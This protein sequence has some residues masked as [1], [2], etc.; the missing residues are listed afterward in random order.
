MAR[1]TENTLVTR[2]DTLDLVSLFAGDELPEW[3][4][5]MV[6]DHILRDD[7]DDD[8]G[9]PDDSNGGGDPDGGDGDKADAPAKRRTTRAKPTPKSD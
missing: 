7:P 3:A 9:D 6:G 4:V 2:P 5:G 8:G 1:L